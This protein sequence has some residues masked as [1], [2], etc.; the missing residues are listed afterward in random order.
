M[1]VRIVYDGT[2]TCDICLKVICHIH[3][4]KETFHVLDSEPFT[5]TFCPKCFKKIIKEK[6]KT[7]PL[8]TK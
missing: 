2:I 8:Q 6:A 1:A 5:R 7:N 3:A 4:S